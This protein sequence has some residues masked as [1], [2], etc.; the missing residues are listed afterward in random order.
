[1]PLTLEQATQRRERAIEQ[2]RDLPITKYPSKEKL[3]DQVWEVTEGLK[4]V[5]HE[6]GKGV[7]TLTPGM[8]FNPTEKQVQ[9]TLTGRG[10]LIN[11]ARELN[12]SEYAGIGRGDRKPMSRGADI[13]LR[14]LPMAEGTRKLA[15]DNG[16]TEDDFKG[17]E[18]GHGGKYTK[19]QVEDLIALKQSGDQ[20]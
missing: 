16:L 11:K 19:E 10:G 14:A 2:N 3:S 13:G 12:G 7:R 17:T 8:R 9:Q 18:P 20:N 5:P 4:H 15:W 6:S 1:M